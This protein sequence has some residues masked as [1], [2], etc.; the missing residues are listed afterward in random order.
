MISLSLFDNKPVLTFHSVQERLSKLTDKRKE[1]PQTPFNII[2]TTMEKISFSFPFDYCHLILKGKIADDHYAKELDEQG[3]ELTTW[4]T[5]VRKVT[6]NHNIFEGLE[7]ENTAK[8]PEEKGQEVALAVYGD[9]NLFLNCTL[10]STQDTLFVGPLPD[11]LSTR[12]LGFLP[13]EERYHEGNCTNYFSHC[14]IKGTVD[15]I[16]GAGRAL[17]YQCDL[18]TLND[19]RRETYVV[20]PSHSLKDDFGYYFES[21]CFLNG[22]AEKESTFLARPWRDYGKAVFSNCTYEDH[23]HPLLFHDWS[24]V[25]RKKTCRLEEYPLKEGRASFTRNKKGSVLPKQ[26]RALLDEFKKFNA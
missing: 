26:Y 22:G 3:K 16:F 25:D 13:E 18:I 23:I 1:D 15:F 24:D 8:R 21:C 20:A 9:D 4:K 2:L 12:Y 5:P 17:F 10:V 7:I 19:K 6:G 11:D 14:T